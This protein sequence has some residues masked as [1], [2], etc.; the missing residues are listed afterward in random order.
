MHTRALTLTEQGTLYLNANTGQTVLVN[1]LFT[2]NN[3]ACPYTVSLVYNSVYSQQMF[4]NNVNADIHTA[5]F[6]KMKLGYGWKLNSQIS[7]TEITIPSYV[8]GND[9]KYLIYCDAD[10]TEHYFAESSSRQQ[11]I[12][13]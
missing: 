6:T 8:N 10:G 5:D 3:L 2:T 4:T 13:G 12:Q 1:D 11:Y 9:A 7:V